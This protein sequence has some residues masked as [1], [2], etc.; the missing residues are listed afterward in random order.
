MS[1]YP[2]LA[3]ANSVLDVAKSQGKSL[4]IMQLLKLVY[5]AH[6]W[7][8]GLLDQP[9]VNE[10]VCAWQH[11][12]VYPSVYRE[13]RRFGSAPITD[14]AKIPLYGDASANLLPQQQAILE[15][16]VRNYGSIHAF[17]LSEMTHQADTPWSEVYRNGLGRGEVIS[18]ELIGHHYKRLIDDRTRA[19]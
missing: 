5:I 19:G 2:A 7:T 6:G 15:S 11:G 13:F 14:K 18:D 1:A 9:L 12:P 10:P 8:L 4:T 3:V 16:V 17:R